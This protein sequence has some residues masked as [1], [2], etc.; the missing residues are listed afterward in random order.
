MRW[1][2]FAY[3]CFV[4]GQVFHGSFFWIDFKAFALRDC[5]C[6]GSGKRHQSVIERIT[7]KDAA[8]GLGINRGHTQMAS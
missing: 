2:G 3:I 4:P 6:V 5:A 8:K 1:Y 7:V